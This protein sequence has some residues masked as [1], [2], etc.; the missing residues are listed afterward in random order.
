MSTCKRKNTQDPS[1][2]SLRR[3]FFRVI[4]SFL[5]SHGMSNSSNVFELAEVSSVVIVLYWAD[6]SGTNAQTDRVISL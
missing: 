6:T 5:A 3:C 1:I 2:P 4:D